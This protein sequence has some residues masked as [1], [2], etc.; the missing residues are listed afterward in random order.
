MSDLS[1]WEDDIDTFWEQRRN[2]LGTCQAIGK[3]T[4]RRCGFRAE[5]QANGRAY[6]AKHAPAFEGVE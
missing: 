2:H 4:H 5:V 6:C 3:H 1:E